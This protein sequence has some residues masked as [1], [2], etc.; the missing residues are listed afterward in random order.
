[1]RALY[2]YYRYSRSSI[3]VP[4]QLLLNIN[5]LSLACIHINILLYFEQQVERGIALGQNERRREKVQRLK[6]TQMDIFSRTACTA[7]RATAF[8]WHA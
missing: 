1:M 4:K 7:S 5:W 2:Q 3:P 8:P 6:E